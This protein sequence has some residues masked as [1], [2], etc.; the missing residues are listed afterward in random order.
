MTTQG[1]ENALEV[2]FMDVFKRHEYRLYTLV[3]HLTKSD[4][5]AK[6]VIHE[7]FMK[8]WLQRSGIYSIVNVESWLYKLTESKVID[9]LHKTSAERKLRDALWISMRN[10][11]IEAIE[12]K[13]SEKEYT[14]IIDKAIDQLPP[15]RKRIYRLSNADSLN[16]QEFIQYLKISKGTLKN[17]FTKVIYSI[18]NI[19]Q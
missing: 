4:E 9:F 3:L 11:T 18:R 10:M 8:L 19:F 2:Y 6:D 13:I 17:Q 16:Y 12:E 14:S 5:Y 7:V 15:Q 1:V